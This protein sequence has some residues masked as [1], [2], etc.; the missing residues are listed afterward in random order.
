MDAGL[1]KA[2]ARKIYSHHYSRERREHVGE[3]VQI[4]GSYHAWLEERGPKACLLVFADD[5]TSAIL[6]A[7][8]VPTVWGSGIPDSDRP[9]FEADGETD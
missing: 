8:F 9:Q 4:D 5:A 1:W 3:L 6:A 7:E 2:K